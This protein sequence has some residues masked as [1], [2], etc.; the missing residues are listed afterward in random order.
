MRPVFLAALFALMLLLLP[1]LARVIKGPSVF[2]RVAALNG[3]GT[4]V[5]AMLV[6]IGQ[7]YGAVELYVDIALALF[8]LNLFT[9]LLIAH[10]VRRGRE[11]EA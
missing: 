10:Y 5:P 3:L 6:L 8:L 9:T 11:G 4:L 7:L 1:F 2:D